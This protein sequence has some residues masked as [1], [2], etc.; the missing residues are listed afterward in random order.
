VL[1]TESPECFVEIGVAP[2]NFRELRF[3]AWWKDAS[4]LYYKVYKEAC[5]LLKLL[6]NCSRLTKSLST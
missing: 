1:I 3:V 2:F 5:D 4:A 6:Q